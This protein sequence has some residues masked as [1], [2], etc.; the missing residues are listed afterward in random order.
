MTSVFF[1]EVLGEFLSDEIAEFIFGR[2]SWLY[3]DTHVP[4]A[5]GAPV[6][7]LWVP[8][9]DWFSVVHTMSQ[10]AARLFVPQALCDSGLSR[11]FPVAFGASAIPN[12]W[13]SFSTTCWGSPNFSS[14]ASTVA[15]SSRGTNALSATSTIG[16]ACA[17]LI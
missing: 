17:A 6:P 2:E 16:T 4:I 14:A 15:R 12:R 3:V 10:L 13:S 9:Q 8:T 11:A 1:S 5:S 7:K